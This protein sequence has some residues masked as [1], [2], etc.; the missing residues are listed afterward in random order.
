MFSI[1]LPNEKGQGLVEYA[2]IM[3]LV[4][5][6]VIAA[7]SLLGPQVGNVY[8]DIIN[9]FPGGDSTPDPT[10]VPTEEPMG[11]STAPEAY[12]VWCS[13]QPAGTN[14]HIFYNAITGKYLGMAHAATPPPGFVI[15]LHNNCPTSG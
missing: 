4:S 12:S 7:L 9:L 15:Y 3:V 5:V 6:V 8:S 14:I 13:T 11:Y 1:S 10:P 2:L